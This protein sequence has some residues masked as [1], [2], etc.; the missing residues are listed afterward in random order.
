MCNETN[1]NYTP[2]VELFL[3]YARTQRRRRCSCVPA[4]V[5][6]FVSLRVRFSS[7]ILG[8]SLKHAVKT[9][10][11]VFP[12]HIDFTMSRWC[13]C[14]MTQEMGKLDVIAQQQKMRNHMVRYLIFRITSSCHTHCCTGCTRRASNDAEKVIS[15][16]K[17][18]TVNNI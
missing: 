18:E 5:R 7:Q 16:H 2:K 13:L 10:V 17:C 4:C 15:T 6:L 3:L 8:D 1:L 12:Q 11:V 14:K 9:V